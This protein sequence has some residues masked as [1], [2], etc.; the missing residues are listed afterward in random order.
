ML[1][2]RHV[3]GQCV[4]SSDE[5]AEKWNENPCEIA[6]LLHHRGRGSE[7]LLPFS[8]DWINLRVYEFLF[9]LVDLFQ[10]ERD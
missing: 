7:S 9:W 10:V 1:K 8:F 3:V 6:H 2:I 5:F 4:Y